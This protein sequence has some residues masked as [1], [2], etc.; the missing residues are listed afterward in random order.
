ML[1][2]FLFQRVLNVT[3]H[4][5]SAPRTGKRFKQK[6]LIISGTESNGWLNSPRI[7]F[8]VSFCCIRI[9]MNPLALLLNTKTIKFIYFKHVC[10]IWIASVFFLHKILT[11][12]IMRSHFWPIHNCEPGSCLPS[13][14][15]AY[16]RLRCALMRHDTNCMREKKSIKAH[17]FSHYWDKRSTFNWKHTL[18]DPAKAMCQYQCYFWH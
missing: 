15:A 11:S 2:W 12:K 17:Y 16:F 18:V 4:I 10:S 9:C 8:P 3:H 1:E 5:C 7:Y 6:C 14:V 13:V